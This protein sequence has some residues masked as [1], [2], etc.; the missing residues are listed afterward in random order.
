[1]WGR[2]PV[3][4]LVC[5]LAAGCSGQGTDGR[6]AATPTARQVADYGPPPTG[7]ALL[8]LQDPAH[9]GWYVG[10]DWTG[11]P[12]STIK[13][14]QPLGSNGTLNQAP[15]GSA[16]AVAPLGKGRF[17]QYLDRLGRPIAGDSQTVYASQIWADDSSRLCTLDY[18]SGAGEWRIGVRAPGATAVE[19]PVAFGPSVDTPGIFALAL[20]TCSP[21]ND[22]AVATYSFTGLPAQVW[23]VRPSDGA[24]LLHQSHDSN[25]LSSIVA[26]Q[27]GSLIANNSSASIGYIGGPTEPTTT[28]VRQS[29]GARLMK[30]DPTIGILDFS[31]DDR[32]VLTTSPWASGV[33]TRLAV[34]DVATGNVL[35]RSDGTEELA[36]YLFNP[37]GSGFAVMLKSTADREVHPPVHVVLVA[38][39]GKATEVPG[40]Y[41]RP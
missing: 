41:L 23:V 25:L 22:R 14:A 4:L 6:S 31:A 5:V 9:A 38:G 24:I 34:M 40:L 3:A 21:R 26:S 33:A 28:V 1:M 37:A 16:F 13:L 17:Q 2:A 12:R 8:Y 20:V 29:D 10:F 39:D 27:D 19:K 30:L 18:A 7:V 11:K 35:W 32:T 36:G 15:D